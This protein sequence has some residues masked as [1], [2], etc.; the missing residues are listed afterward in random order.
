[1][2]QVEGGEGHGHSVRTGAV[3]E[4]QSVGLQ[5]V[6]WIRQQGLMARFQFASALFVCTMEPFST[7][8]YSSVGL[9]PEVLSRN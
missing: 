1:M 9:S 5:N 2:S 8:K 3:P 4:G 6:R 7:S